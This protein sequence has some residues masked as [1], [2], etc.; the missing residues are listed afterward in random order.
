MP[1]FYPLLFEPVLHEKVWGNRQLETKLGK[2]LPPNQPIGESWEIFWKNRIANGEFRGQTLG[3]VIKAF[4]QEMTGKPDADPEFPLLIKFLDAQDWLSVQ[5][6]PDDARAAVLEGEPRGKT[7][8]WYI[9]DAVPDAQIA[10]GF[11]EQL[12]AESYRKAIEAGRNKEVLQFVTVKPGDF[13]YLPAGQIHA[14]GPGIL[15]YELQQT[16]DTTYR[17]YDWDRLGLDGKPRDLHLEK[18]LQ[19]IDFAVKPQAQVNYA[20][21]ANTGGVTTTT[22][23]AGKYFVLNKLALEDRDLDNMTIESQDKAQALTVT[24]GQITLHDSANS[25]DPITLSIGQS[26]FLPAAL[27]PIKIEFQG[28]TEVLLAYAQDS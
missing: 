14:M 5:V 20:R 25:Y 7:E 9:I 16:S 13:I 1:V 12:D 23:I 21:P 8:C 19:C 28:D 26:T 27:G 6:H 18:A 24:R 11:S 10:Y 17:V 3:D 4:P 2:N 15:L 22:L